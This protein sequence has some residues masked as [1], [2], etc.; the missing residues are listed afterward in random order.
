MVFFQAGIDAT[1]KAVEKAAELATE[2]A[3]AEAIVF[4]KEL[5]QETEQEIQETEIQKAY[6]DL[7]EQTEE[8]QKSRAN[9]AELQAKVK[10]MAAEAESTD[11]KLS[12]FT[13]HI[14]ELQ[15]Q[16]E[17]L[18]KS[19]ASEAELQAKVKAMAAEVESTDEKMSGFTAHI[20]ELHKEMASLQ[21][22][23]LNNN[24]SPQRSR[25]GTSVK[26]TRR[27]ERINPR[28]IDLP[29]SD[30]ESESLQRTQGPASPQHAQ[31]E[32]NTEHE[33]SDDA[34]QKIKG[35]EAELQA[36]VKAMAAEAESVRSA[37]EE[38]ESGF[39]IN[40]DELNKELESLQRTCLEIQ[41]EKQQSNMKKTPTSSE[42][43][44]ESFADTLE[45]SRENEAELQ[46]KV[47]AM[48]AEAECVRVVTEG[49]INS[50]RAN[51]E[52][53]NKELAM[54]QK[55]VMELQDAERNG[56]NSPKSRASTMKVKKRR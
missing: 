25:G 27:R 10:A 24:P 40:I 18:Q 53:M 17:E 5:E 39:K 55:R 28:T 9:E 50:L 20:E 43:Q 2:A 52:E 54:F 13:A 21:S 47:K 22:S 46:A 12:G 16:T 35:R 56:E 4:M 49:K 11:E 37:T 6:D 1:A 41:E 33:S 8:L 14:V 3:K 26:H 48:A 29:F 42:E 36:K 30:T 31:L 32:S 23:L 45:K 51:C 7:K 38:K 19:R 15:E 44:T 34:L